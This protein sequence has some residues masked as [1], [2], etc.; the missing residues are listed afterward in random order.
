MKLTNLGKDVAGVGCLFKRLDNSNPM[1]RNITLA[2]TSAFGGY[3]TSHYQSRKE[4]FVEAITFAAIKKEAI[5]KI[6]GYPAGDDSELNILL[7]KFGYKLYNTT[8][9][10]V[11][12]KFIRARIWD[13]VI[14][15][16]DYGRARASDIKQHP[17]SFK[18]IYIT[19]SFFTL[20]LLLLSTI[21]FI[22]PKYPFSIIICGL[23]VIY[24]LVD[25]IA[26]VHIGLKNNFKGFYWLIILFPLMHIGYGLGFLIG[27]LPR[28][29]RLV[30]K[31]E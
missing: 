7:R 10:Y 15:M 6:G 4:G 30:K 26:S 31:R 13:F 22:F 18:F 28:K 3:G 1:A 21:V 11:Y 16:I 14:R 23:A 2:M 25:F 12:Y 29:K 20:L 19:P 24:L 9:T 5:E 8:E 27:L 17:S